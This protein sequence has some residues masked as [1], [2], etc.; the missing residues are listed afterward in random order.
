[1]NPGD[2]YRINCGCRTQTYGRGRKRGGNIDIQMGKRVT[3]GRTRTGRTHG[4]NTNKYFVTGLIRVADTLFI[5]RSV[6][7][8]TETGNIGNT[9]RPEMSWRA[10]RRGARNDDLDIGFRF[11]YL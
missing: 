2:T 10:S 9:S 4:E 6:R 11:D 1:M 3:H 8:E 5:L 7:P